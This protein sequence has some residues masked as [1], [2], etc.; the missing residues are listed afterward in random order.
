[1]KIRLLVLAVPFS[2]MSCN[3]ATKPT[4]ALAY[5]SSANVVAES[6]LKNGAEINVDSIALDTAKLAQ[7]KEPEQFV[8]KHVLTVDDLYRDYDGGNELSK[9]FDIQLI[10]RDTY[11]SN[12]KSAVNFLLY[13]S[14]SL[15]K[16]NGA[17]RLPLEKGMLTLTDNIV[18]NDKLK[19]YRYIGQF[20]AL[21]MYLVQGVFWEDWSYILYDKNNG[22][23]VQS[24]IGVPYL[25]TDFKYIACIEVDSVEGVG[26][27]SLYAISENEVTKKKYIDPIVEMYVKSWVP[28]TATDNIY[29]GTDGY[30]YAPVMYA[31][32]FWDAQGNY[33]GLDQYIRIRPLAAAVA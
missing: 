25:S 1:M 32:N 26:N 23:E 2:L 20:K 13:D 19:E 18:D 28:Y 6:L 8:E 24:F 9:F 16:K 3:N 14:A 29:W 7:M 4:D 27:L 33:Y 21:N 10:D 12:R 17:L 11:L 31:A 30:L 5:N 22:R 15:I